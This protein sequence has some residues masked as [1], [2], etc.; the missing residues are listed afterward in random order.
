[1]VK[2]KEKKGEVID[3]IFSPEHTEKYAIGAAG[4]WSPYDFR[5]HFYSA[6]YKSNPPGEEEIENEKFA[7]YINS[8]VILPPKPTKELAVWLLA[9]ISDFEKN[10]AE[11]LIE[12]GA[13]LKN[14]IKAI[15]YLS[16]YDIEDLKKKLKESEEG[17]EKEARIEEVKQKVAR[18]KKSK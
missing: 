13:P 4:G 5:I 18:K 14:L 3:T 9:H 8:T 2:N 15:E 12:E 6:R 11:I 16:K 17:A 10:N 1:M 7:Y